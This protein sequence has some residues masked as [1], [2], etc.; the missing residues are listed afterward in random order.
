MGE[1]ITDARDGMWEVGRPL[2]A[3]RATR[4][5]PLAN[6]VFVPLAKLATRRLVSFLI[7]VQP[8]LD[9]L[10]HHTHC[11]SDDEFQAHDK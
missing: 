2:R 8:I 1:E 11:R 6:H 9:S 4:A 3:M 7:A 10:G 5:E